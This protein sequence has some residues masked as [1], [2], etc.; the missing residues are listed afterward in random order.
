MNYR[1]VS[2]CAISTCRIL[3]LLIR[4]SSKTTQTRRWFPESAATHVLTFKQFRALSSV[5]FPVSSTDHRLPAFAHLCLQL[6][7]F[8]QSFRTACNSN[9][10][11]FPSHFGLPATPL[12]FRVISDCLQLQ[13]FS[14]PFRTACNSSLFPSHFGLP[15]TPVFS[16]AISDCLQLR[17][18][19]QPFRTAA[20][21][22]QLLLWRFATP[23]QLLLWR[24][25]QPA[26]RLDLQ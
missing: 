8:F 6:Q 12:F 24:F 4:D 11:L 9:S 5:Y 22:L 1:F 25:A 26:G 14:Q 18:F 13:S 23:L 3:Q 10:S 20:T 17:S 2:P 7:S 19:P 15:A 16:P 21:P